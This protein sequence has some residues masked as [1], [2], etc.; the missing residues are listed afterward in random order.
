MDNDPNGPIPPR[1]STRMVS[2]FTLSSQRENIAGL[3]V[4]CE[5]HRLQCEGTELGRRLKSVTLEALTPA[6]PG[7]HVVPPFELI[8]FVGLPTEQHD[9][10]IAH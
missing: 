9:A 7:F 6:E 8:A 2:D 1:Q 4:V 3:E 10:A 5:P